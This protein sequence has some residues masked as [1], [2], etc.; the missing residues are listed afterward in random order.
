MD[1]AEQVEEGKGA[2]GRGLVTGASQA[3]DSF[4]CGAQKRAFT[5]V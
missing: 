1:M 4:A 3:V 2:S 5:S